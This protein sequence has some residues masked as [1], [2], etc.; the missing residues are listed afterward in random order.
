MTA[1]DGPGSPIPIVRGPTGNGGALVH[2]SV[3]EQRVTRLG[4]R[5]SGSNV[6]TSCAPSPSG[7]AIRPAPLHEPPAPG[8]DRDMNGG[9]VLVGRIH[10]DL[11]RL[12][13][14]ALCR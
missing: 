6:R 14:V 3:R 10:L 12:Q 1:R 7:W 5:G 4:R 2:L 9:V 8:Q 13:S 11:G